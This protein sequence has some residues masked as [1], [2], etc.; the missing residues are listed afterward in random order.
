MRKFVCVLCITVML[1]TGCSSMGS[2]KHNNLD[3]E[4]AFK[5]ITE[6]VE[7]EGWHIGVLNDTLVDDETL[8]KTY[9]LSK[10]QVLEY[11]IKQAII[12]ADVGEI[13][14][15]KVQEDQE[16][17]VLDAITRRVEQMREEVTG[18][19]SQEKILDAYSIGK[20][21]SY[22]VFVVGLDSSSVLQFISSF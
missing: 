12:P 8:Q 5:K 14:F 21:D 18:L 15:F 13:A 9:G 17:V 7:E 2:M 1:C 16:Q 3:M 19:T 22:I 20:Y 4:K 11:G 6:G 10:E